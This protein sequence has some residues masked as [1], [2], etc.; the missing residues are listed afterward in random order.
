MID[1][2]S[3]W[4]K[5]RRE[6]VTES[7]GDLEASPAPFRKPPSKS[8]F[9]WLVPNMFSKYKGIPNRADTPDPTAHDASDATDDED[10]KKHDHH[11]NS[12]VPVPLSPTSEMS[13]PLPPY[14]SVVHSP[15][16]F[17]PPK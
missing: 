14:E 10:D 13:V 17:M 3:K 8:W 5:R 7:P 12:K 1:W 4:R 16:I 2:V 11:E 15:P 9:S 6:R